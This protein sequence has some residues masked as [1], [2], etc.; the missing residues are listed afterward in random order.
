M[1]GTELSNIIEDT[2]LNPEN[3]T[4]VNTESI[5]SNLIQKK[6]NKLF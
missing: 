5:N 2:I 1:L 4:F 6:S 3:T